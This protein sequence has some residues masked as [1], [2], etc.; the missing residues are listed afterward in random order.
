MA[1]LVIF[2]L[3]PDEI[4]LNVVLKKAVNCILYLYDLDAL[5]SRGRHVGALHT[6]TNLTLAQAR[7]PQ[8]DRGRGQHWISC[9]LQTQ[10]VITQHPEVRIQ[11]CWHRVHQSTLEQYLSVKCLLRPSV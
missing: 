4:W 11:W 5:Q 8:A 6:Q 1:I 10:D 3:D 2:H 7:Q 9:Y